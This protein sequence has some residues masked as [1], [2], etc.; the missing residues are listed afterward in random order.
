MEQ[1]FG[2]GAVRQLFEPCLRAVGRDTEL[3]TGAAAGAAPVFEET[4][5]AA[6]VPHGSFTVLHGLYWVTVNLASEGPLLICVDDVQWAD[7]ASLRYLAYL[8][9]RLEGLPVLLVLARRTGE[10]QPDDALLAEIALDPA[11]TVLRP[12]PLSA[13]AAGRLVRER[14]GDSAESFVGACHRDDLGRSAAAP[15]AAACVGG[16]VG[17]ARRVARRHRASGGV[18]GRLGAGDAAAA[19]DAQRRHGRGARG[20]RAGRGRR[21]AHRRGAGPAARGAGRRSAGHAGP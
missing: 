10:Q 2:F 7:S 18:P 16:R 3:L 8:V 15:A 6:P 9:R 21:A 20:R 4:A 14:L 17:P 1:S 12:A 19:A 5:D 11:V 13:D